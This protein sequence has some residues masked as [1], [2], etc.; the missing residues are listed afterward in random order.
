MCLDGIGKYEIIM[1]DPVCFKIA[2]YPNGVFKVDTAELR[3]MT[4][5]PTHYKVTG[6]LRFKTLDQ[7]DMA[8]M[9]GIRVQDSI[10]YVG[11]EI[12]LDDI[13]WEANWKQYSIWVDA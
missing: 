12:E 5:V 10:E 11:D 9:I 8:D 2:D 7:S 1:Q 13:T 4:M 6:E 3:N